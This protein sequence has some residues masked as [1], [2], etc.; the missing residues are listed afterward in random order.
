MPEPG[1]ASRPD[2]EQWRAL[3]ALLDEVLERAP[4]ERVGW[5]AEL[6]AARPEL[7]R[8]LEAMLAAEPEMERSGFL[9]DPRGLGWAGEESP[10]AGLR[11][12]S[13]TLERPLG[14]GGMG[15]V[16]LARRSDGRYEGQAAVKLLNLALLDPIGLARFTREGS[17]LARLAHP[18]I[19]R[20]IDAGVSPAG[21][22]FLV[23][24]HVEGQPIDRYCESRGCG[25]AER[26]GLFR[27]VLDAVAHAHANLIVHRDLKPSNILVAGDGTVK[28][29]DFGIAKLLEADTAGERTALTLDG[30][31]AFTP[32]YAAPE[33]ARGEPVTTATDVY[34]LGVLL[35]LLVSGRHPTTRDSHTPADSMRALE[36]IEPARLGLGDL[37]TVLAKALRK[38][39]GERY[40][41][42]TAF[43]DDIGRYLRHEPVSARPAALAYRAGRFLRR[44]RAV[45]I[46]G[47]LTGAGLVGATL[48]SVAQMREARRQRDAA[49]L[50]RRRAD[51]Q[52]EFQGLLVSQVGE[53]PIT[54]R[55]ILDRAR[56]SI[57]LEH[58]G[59]PRFL[60][61]ILLELS[62]RYSELGDTRFRARLLA[63]AES[64]VSR[65]QGGVH[66]AAI[67]CQMADN[68]RTEGEYDSARVMF[69]RADALLRANP[70]AR[71]EIDCLQARA[72]YAHEIR[73]GQESIHAIERA[74]ALKEGLGETE[75][76]DYLGLLGTYATSLEVAGRGR[77]ALG[78]YD[79]VIRGMDQSGRGLQM[80]R[81]VMQHNKAVALVDMGET[82]AAER[83]LREVLGRVAGSDNGRI[84]W[85]PLIHYAETA[86]DAAHA[87]SA[88][89]YFGVLY[90]QA[91][92]DTN[93]YWQGRGAFGLARAQAR[94]GRLADARRTAERF[95]R[96]ATG[97]PRLR[98][99]DD[100][101][102]DTSTLAG[103][104]ALT[105]GDTAA[106]YPQFLLALR[107][108]GYYEGKRQKQMRAV[109]LLAAE[110]GLALGW[111]D[112][113]LRY[114]RDAA[115]IARKDSLT[116]LRSARVGE[117]RLIEG[118]ALLARGDTAAGR[119]ALAGAL[120][121]L[122]TGAGEGHPR[123][124]EAALRLSALGAA[125]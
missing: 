53:E 79:R 81:T 64:L 58:A 48:F 37:D 15:S 124:R 77:E 86:L 29:L 78:V 68:L 115:R 111:P 34:A 105:A 31:R 6:R 39:A 18:N 95:R 42:V 76:M 101:M 45:V 61:A 7:A 91:V 109:A 69:D 24:E 75:G 1:T 122:R 87:D 92:R 98:A 67:R 123:T 83:E 8:E 56:E 38:R 23:L 106:A 59:D 46:A 14:R 9:S 104:L 94:L 119:A 26:L 82:A 66:L 4:A 108:H 97:F 102:P 112:T 80:T 84:H 12:G 51:A 50:E 99:T 96:V 49:V 103:I 57:E 17:L 62:N 89:K 118:R 19:A 28:L 110:T 21:Q 90:D 40:Q 121:A 52:V 20:L 113:A 13:Y 47:A 72:T 11:L 2:A 88:A 65:G 60:G 36:E 125:P 32:E 93:R 116:E 117:A 100:Q 63:R 5:L 41:S 27:Q 71:A 70:D 55:Q 107:E 16:W 10:L 73:D 44:N 22:P 33:Q 35:Y 120:R 43:A 25:L 74:I 3:E 30:G 114:A 54:M 85:Q